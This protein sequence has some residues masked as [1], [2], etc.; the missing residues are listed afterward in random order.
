MPGSVSTAYTLQYFLGYR[1][2]PRGRRFRW[3][4]VSGLPGG[5]LR[6]STT[7]CSSCLPSPR[8]S[9]PNSIERAF[10]NEKTLRDPI[11]PTRPLGVHQRASSFSMVS[12]GSVW[13]SEIFVTRLNQRYIASR[14]SW[15]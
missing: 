10:V 8:R 11:S 13:A 2:A 5:S 9:L 7:A 1:R 6:H 12:F 4:G 3:S 14:F 15:V